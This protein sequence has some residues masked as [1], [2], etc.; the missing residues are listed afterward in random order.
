MYFD[1]I[2]RP[3]HTSHIHAPT[4][5]CIIPPPPPPLYKLPTKPCLCCLY[6]L[7]DMDSS[8]G[9]LPTRAHTDLLSV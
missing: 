7:E 1:H 6:T 4:L 8:G 2:Y 5:L 3:P 9:G